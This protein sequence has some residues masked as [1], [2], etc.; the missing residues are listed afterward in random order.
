MRVTRTMNRRIAVAGATVLLAASAG[1]AVLAQELEP[2]AVH[3]PHP[4][5]IHGGACDAPGDSV[6][7]L[8][9]VVLGTDAAVGAASAVPVEVSATTV[10]IAFDDLFNAPHSI[11]VHDSAE[12]GQPIACAEIG[13]QMLGEDDLAVALNDVGGSG[14]RGVAS[15]HREG[16]TSVNVTVLLLTDAAQGGPVSP[17]Q[18][19]TPGESVVPVT[20]TVPAGETT[21]PLTTT[22]PT[23]TMGVTETLVPTLVPTT[24]PTLIAG[25]TQVP[26]MTT[27]PSVVPMTTTIPVTS[28]VPVMT[29]VPS[30]VPSVVTTTVPSVVPLTTTVPGDAACPS[31]DPA[32]SPDPA[33]TPC[34]SP[35]VAAPSASPAS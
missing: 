35:A 7:A 5:A 10:E 13:G 16:D 11:L 34:V 33:A 3:D 1:A 4:A 30:V 28:E 20:T 19:A 25:E 21:V 23:E 17:G 14:H 31:L 24:V 26:L 6:A 27:V 22:V 15:F 18:S 29:T 32:L 12:S 9:D 2:G 8:N